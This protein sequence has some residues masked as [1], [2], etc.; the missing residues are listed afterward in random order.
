MITADSE[1]HCQE[2]PCH[3]RLLSKLLA[4]DYTN[5]TSCSLRLKR[6]QCLKMTCEHS[7]FSEQRVLRT[8]FSGVQKDGFWRRR[9]NDELSKYADEPSSQKMVKSGSI[10]CPTKMVFDGI[11]VGTRRP[12]E[13]QS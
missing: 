3:K 7:M 8:I 5:E 2:K 9:M 13:E 10:R 11:P 6:E 4:T 1:M 12:P